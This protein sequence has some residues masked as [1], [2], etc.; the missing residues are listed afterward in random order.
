MSISRPIKL[1]LGALLVVG[2]ITATLPSQAADHAPSIEIT[3]VPTDVS[4]TGGSPSVPVYV[5]L[6]EFASDKAR[7]EVDGVGVVSTYAENTPIFMGAT[8]YGIPPAAF[9]V[10][11]GTHITITITT[12]NGPGQSGGAS[13]YSTLIYE[14]GT[15]TLINLENLIAVPDSER[16][17][18]DLVPIP[19][20]AVVGTF[21]SST[22]LYFDDDAGSATDSM[23]DAGKTLWVL[24]V[25]AS[26]TYYQ[27]L[28]SGK[29][30]WV[31][32]GTIG[33]TYDEVWNGT[34]LPTTVVN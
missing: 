22:P 21:T 2:T 5:N 11:S 7:M 23:M 25:N 12:Y 31:P 10:P 20:E 13:Y 33:P 27:V 3:G 4:C 26:G 28:L 1:L 15:G 16:P 29:M 17:G 32:V 18:A 30:Y 9:S 6:P 34:P 24:G 19:S 14:C 8:F